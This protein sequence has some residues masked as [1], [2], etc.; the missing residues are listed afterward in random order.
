MIKKIWDAIHFGTF[1][2]QWRHPLSSGNDSRAQ[3]LTRTLFYESRVEQTESGPVLVTKNGGLIGRQAF[4]LMLP[5]YA[6]M[7]YGIF[8]G[9]ATLFDVAL[10]EVFF[11]G[12]FG[13]MNGWAVHRLTQEPDFGV[14]ALSLR[15]VLTH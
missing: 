5:I 7:A 6:V 3:V 13:F 11:I 12:L 10:I 9:F 14:E 15:Q 2:S 1:K 4:Y 8:A